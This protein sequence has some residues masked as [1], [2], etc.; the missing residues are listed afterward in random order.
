MSASLF[1][2][3]V[4]PE[5]THVLFQRLVD[6]DALAAAR[7][8]MDLVFAEFRDVDGN[9]VREFQT[10]G[11]SARVYELALFAYLREF[12]R[13]LDREHPAPDFVVRGKQPVAIEVTTTNPRQGTP[14]TPLT[15]YSSVPADLETADREFVHQI[16][17][18]IRK[19]MQHLIGGQHYWDQAHVRG[20]PFVI[21][22][23]AFHNDHA[24]WHPMS[25]VAEYLYGQR[26]VLEKVPG[27]PARVVLEKIEDHEF[28]G[29]R[30]PSALFTQDGL[31]NLAGV[32]F[33]NA[34]GTGKFNRIGIEHGYG[35]PG[36]TV[37]RIG[38]CFDP[39]PASTRPR[40]FGY[41]VVR[42]PRD[43]G[44]RENF[45]EGLHLFLNPW[46]STQLS[47]EALPGITV[48]TVVDGVATTCVLPA[49]LHPYMS[50]NINVS[51]EKA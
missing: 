31:E 13:E 7:S 38:I 45:A 32:L 14:S 42:Q 25:L 28:G 10:G 49:G 48:W 8:F 51:A 33:S 23:G 40:E 21:A 30:I 22:V 4:P 34:H 3:Q 1:D 39:D 26:D 43:S 19:K 46:A 29:R 2:L 47:P 50:V 35:V 6:G 44:V 17:K 15:E 36:V 20:V 18:A 37:V 41:E 9:F 11:F 12:G 27:A 16:G 24:H 5:K